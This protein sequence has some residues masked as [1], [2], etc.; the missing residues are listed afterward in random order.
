MAET[1]KQTR[2]FPVPTRFTKLE[3]ETITQAASAAGVTMSD[4][5]RASALSQPLPPP[6]PKRANRP[7]VK[8]GER[9]STLLLAVGRIGNN[10]NQLAHVANAGDWP[11]RRA[12]QT[13]VADIQWMRHTLMLALGVRDYSPEQEQ[14]AP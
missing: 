7:T 6:Q 3:K 13:A 11:E 14:P 2:D 1:H 5:I 10:A 9:L 8:D 12:L 4:F